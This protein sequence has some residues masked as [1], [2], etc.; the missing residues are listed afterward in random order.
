MLFSSDVNVPNKSAILPK[1]NK[2]APLLSVDDEVIHV[3]S[4]VVMSRSRPMYDDTTV[5]EPVSKAPIAIAIVA[6]NTNN[7]SWTVVLKHAGRTLFVWTGSMGSMAAALS[8]EG[9]F[10]LDRLLFSASFSS[11]ILAMCRDDQLFAS[12]SCC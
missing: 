1:N 10:G 9:V 8:F 4:A 12:R 11:P 3:I 5:I 6:V 7:T 2:K